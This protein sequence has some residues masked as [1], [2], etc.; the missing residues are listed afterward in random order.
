MLR[1]AGSQGHGR[2]AA[3]FRA[4]ELPVRSGLRRPLFA[5]TLGT[6]S[7]GFITGSSTSRLRALFSS[8]GLA[9][10]QRINISQTSRLSSSAV[11]IRNRSGHNR[12]AR[13]LSCPPAMDDTTPIRRR[14]SARVQVSLERMASSA[15]RTLAG[16]G[17]GQLMTIG[18]AL[19]QTPALPAIGVSADLSITWCYANAV[20][21]FFGGFRVHHGRN[22]AFFSGLVGIPSHLVTGPR[23]APL[24]FQFNTRRAARPSRRA[25]PPSASV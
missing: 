7:S 2:H 11:S 23:L 5:V 12:P 4:T 9:L 6:H 17:P 22:A 1:I 10:H 20:Q 15:C 3:G 19:Q 8:I 24:H 25:V 18:L 14:V 21:A 13:Q 16:P